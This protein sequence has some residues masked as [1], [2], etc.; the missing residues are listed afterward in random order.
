M[1]S[2]RFLLQEV[3]SL[4]ALGARLE[5]VLDAYQESLGG[6]SSG[7]P[8]ELL[9][10]ATP[11]VGEL[12]TL[13]LPGP[14]DA[15]AEHSSEDEARTCEQVAPE[16]STATSA[17]QNLDHSCAIIDSNMQEVTPLRLW[18]MAMQKYEVLQGLQEQHE[19]AK[20]NPHFFTFK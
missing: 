18:N 7:V 8:R 6:K 3:L 1:L 12:R 4:H 11:M 20:G 17:A 2:E 13:H 10:A 16:T 5:S 9:A 14:A 19:Q 15:V